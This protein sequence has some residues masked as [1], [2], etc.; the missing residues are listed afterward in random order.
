MSSKPCEP[1]CGC[2]LHR[3]R[4]TL[5]PEEKR[6][7]GR[8][9]RH[10]SYQKHADKRRAEARAWARA[11]PEKVREAGRRAN[12]RKTR[13]SRRTADQTWRY[14]LPPG[15]F[16]QMIAV[17]DGCCIYCAKKIDFTQ[18]KSFAIDHD[19][20]CCPGK[21]S[22][23]DCVLGIACARCNLGFGHFNDDPQL[24]I[25]AAQ[26]RSWLMSVAVIRRAMS[27]KPVQE[28]LPINVRRLERREESA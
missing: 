20:G 7:R 17:N 19:H 11:N 23:G 8:E 14:G 15:A 13:E 12:A 18:P 24:M 2:G 26:K 25:Q 22:C 4:P 9:S 6:R 16:E 1:G 10:R 28:E 3:A 27:P 21:K 5:S